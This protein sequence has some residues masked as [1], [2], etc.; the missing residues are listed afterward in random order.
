[1]ESQPFWTLFFKLTWIPAFFL[2]T[3]CSMDSPSISLEQ[4]VFV[5]FRGEN[6]NITCNLIKAVNQTED[7]CLTCFDPKNKTIYNNTI[8]TMDT[9]QERFS[10]HLELK[11]LKLSGLYSCQYQTVKVDWFLRVTD[12]GYK[13]PVNTEFIIM[14]IFTGVLLIFSVLGSLYVFR[15]H[16][17]EKH[18]AGEKKQKQSKEEKKVTK[19]EDDSLDGTAAQSY[20]ASL[21]PR[22]RSIYDVLDSSPARR[23]NDQDKAIPKKKEPPKKAAQKTKDK[24]EGVFESVYE[25]F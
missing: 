11:N 22:P 1:M 14:A 7:G 8:P 21:E 5:A 23:E 10:W 6:L 25:N 19:K 2:L 9:K 15:G 24:D 4:E 12:E 17:T 16:W 3:V 18:G 13:E 20:Y